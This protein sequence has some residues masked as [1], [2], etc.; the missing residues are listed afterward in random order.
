MKVV[1][2]VTCIEKSIGVLQIEAPKKRFILKDVAQWSK[3]R[4][5]GLLPRNHSTALEASMG[6]W[7]R[8]FKQL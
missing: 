8:V 5:M 6:K 7:L 3:T 4:E 2:L 1:L